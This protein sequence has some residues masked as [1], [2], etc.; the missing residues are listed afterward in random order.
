MIY[1]GCTKNN[2]KSLDLFAPWASQND[3]VLLM[4]QAIKCWGVVGGTDKKPEDIKDMST[5]YFTKNYSQYKF[6]KSLIKAVGAP[7][8]SKLD[9]TKR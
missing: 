6:T 1:H 5:N 7:I 8:D 2:E 4:P 9:Y 3:L